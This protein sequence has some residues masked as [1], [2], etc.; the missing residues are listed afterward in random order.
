MNKHHALR[1]LLLKHLW[2]LRA[3]V[4]AERHRRI[5]QSLAIEKTA[6]T[7][8]VAWTDGDE[9]KTFE[10]PLDDIALWAGELRREAMPGTK[11]WA[12]VSRARL[13][14]SRTT[15]GVRPRS[16]ASSGSDSSSSVA[17]WFWP[18]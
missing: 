5:A 15:S 6:N 11:C 8:V 9:R 4:P 2:M 16:V 17:P 1:F 7:W 14:G 12:S 13:W 10:F 18:R 3:H